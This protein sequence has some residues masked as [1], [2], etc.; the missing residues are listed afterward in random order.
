MIK[1][2]QLRLSYLT[3]CLLSFCLLFLARTISAQQTPATGIPPFGSFGGGPEAINLSNLNIHLNIPIISK[4]GRGGGFSYALAYDG[5]IYSPTT[6]SGSQTW[7]PVVNWGWAGQTQISTGYVFYTR[8]T[9]DCGSGKGRVPYNIYTFKKYYDQYGTIHTFNIVVNDSVQNCTTPVGLFGGSTTLTDGSGYT[10]SVDA[11]PSATVASTVATQFKPPVGTSVGVGSSTDR[12]GNQI[13]TD[14]AGKFFDTLNS[15][16]PVLTVSGSGTSTSPLVFTYT[17]S[18]PSSSSCAST[19]TAGVACYAVSYTN[20]TVATNFGISGISEYRSAAA[21]P[22]VTSITLPNGSQYAITYEPTPGTCSPY[23]GTTC[24]TARI[25]SITLPTGGILSYVYNNNG[26]TFSACTVGSNGIYSDGSASCLKRTTPDGI[27]SYI[28]YKGTG[29]ASAT[30]VTPPTLPYDTSANQSIVQFQGIYETQRNVYQ[31]SAPAFSALPIIEGTLQTAGILREV[32][33]CYNASVSPCPTTAVTL[34]ITQRSVVTVLSGGGNLQSKHADFYNASGMKTESDEYDFGTG[35]PGALLKKTLITFASLGNNLNAFRQTV[36]VQ[37][38]TGAVKYRQDT[39]YDQYGSGMACVTTAPQ[40]DNTGHGCSFTSRGNTT[41]ITT[42]QDPVTP[43]GGISKSFTYDSLGNMLTAQVSCCELKTAAFSSTTGYAYPDSIVQGGSSPQLTTNYTYDLN[44]GLQLTS[45][46]PNNLSTVFG[47]DNMGRP[48]TVTPGSNPAT[49]YTYTDSGTRSVQICSPIQG[50]NKACQK[51]LVD[52]LGRTAT[53]QLLDG[54]G[55][56]Y[57]AS[58]TQYDPLGRAY[59]SSNPYT[60]SASLWTK[61]NFDGLGRPLKST[62]QD[63]S[64]STVSYVDNTVLTSDPAGKQRKQVGDALGRLTSVYEPD[65]ANSNQLTLVTS[66]AYNVLDNLT[67]VTQGSQTRTFVYDALGRLSS[68]TT[69]EAGQFCLGTVAGGVCQANGYDFW[70]N[71]IYRTDARGVQASYI[72]D[73][74]NRL[75][76]IT[77]SNLPAGVAPMPNGCATTGSS[78]NNANVCYAYGT[79]AA[80]HN[81]GRMTNMT[82]P[83]GSEAYVYDQFGNITQLTKTVGS[84]NY[85]LSYTYNL[86]NQ[87]TQITYPSGRIVQQ[88]VDAIGRLCEVAPSTTGCGTA[89][90]PFATGLAYNVANQVT[91]FKYGNAVFASFGFSSDRLQLNCIDY[92]TTNRSGTCTHDA[93]TKFGLNYSYQ[94]APGNNGQISGIIDTVDSGR[95]AT[96]SYDALYRLVSAVT[97]GSTSYP[98]WGLSETYD[99]YGNRTQQTA[100]SGCVGITC[101]QPSVAVS[102]TTNHLTASTFTYDASGN[103]TNDGQNTLVYDGESRTSSATNG[104]SSGTY[105]YDGKG[106]RVKRAS[107]VSGT[108]TTT[109]YVF[110]GGKVLAEYDNGSLPSAAT[111]EYIYAGGKLIA[112]IDTATKYYHQDHL[113]NRAITDSSGSLVAQMGHFPFGESWYNASNDKLTFT[114]YERDKESGNDYAKARYYISR[115]ARFSSPDPVSGDPSNPQSWNRYGY[116]GNDPINLTDPEGEYCVYWSD[117]GSSV[118]SEDDTSDPGECGSNGGS[119]FDDSPDISNDPPDFTDILNN[120][121]LNQPPEPPGYQDC[122]TGALEEVLASGETPGEPNDGYGTLVGGRVASIS[123]PSML[124]MGAYV[125]M[126]GGANLSASAV[127][128][129]SGNPGIYVQVH[130][131]DLKHNFPGD[132][133]QKWSSAFGR[134]QI[135]NTLATQFNMTDWTPS[136][137][138]DAVAGMLRYYGAVQPAMDGNF[139]QAMWNMFKWASMPDAPLPGKKLSMQDAYQTFQDALSYLPE[140]Q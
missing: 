104:S 124:A 123:N 101:P 71:L 49:T 99:R 96:Y 15:S 35:A 18:N 125:G 1:L 121:T 87:L 110:S 73:N 105:T 126:P 45:T 83:S 70:G 107:T 9:G 78:S 56:L 91:G 30:L 79:S 118:E 75:L 114:S 36:K 46:D 20:Y 69:P 47:Y 117:D 137:Q 57:S 38:G 88:S 62:F 11:S 68:M 52:G 130:P 10:I 77:Y 42:Y 98:A 25:A 40:H 5:S 6:A 63:G 2:P 94:A 24:V 86:G 65:P 53:I 89:S 60:S 111:R 13:N 102:A 31:G 134:Y 26:G 131:P 72:Y 74:L 116:V 119:W 59:R 132:P 108:T 19:S 120:L 12:N 115:L 7:T 139:Q 58:D 84:T 90:S 95:N 136:G 4:P 81:N 27:W 85:L 37:D 112:K 43:S 92:S 48:L 16:A 140:C 129:L 51:S 8:I 50:T 3:V 109:V 44:T 32:Q 93:T 113:S 28:Q 14:G 34:P 80:S 55:T 135:T 128:Q 41:S 54:S 64:F 106:L 23:T 76:G 133:P 100:I 67:T 82:D 138:D 22:L 39:T 103:M 66:Y 61:T 17:P 122:I 127:S 33:T 29:A 97:T 21:V